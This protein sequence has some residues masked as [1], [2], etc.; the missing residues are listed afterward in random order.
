MT[1][2]PTNRESPFAAEE[3]FFSTT[4]PKGII[5]ASNEVF[6]RV[7]RHPREALDGHAHNRVRHPDMPRAVFSVFWD[8]LNAGRPIAAYVKNLAADGSWYWVMASVVP[9]AGGFLSVRLKPSTAYLTAA[10]AVYVRL[11]EA[12]AEVEGGDVR[13]R[14]AAITASVELLPQLLAQEGFASYEA[15]MNV[16]LPAEVTAREALL[17]TT[18]RQRLGRPPTVA[19]P[20]LVALLERCAA[21]HDFLDHLVANLEQFAAL[22]RTLED[23]SRFVSDLADS[24]RLFSLNAL[25]ASTRL[26]ADGAALGAVAGLMRSRSDS[27]GPIIAGLSHEI[28]GAVDL[29]GDMGFRIAATKLQT[30]MLMDF[31]HEL[32]AGDVDAHVAAELAPLAGAMAD[33]TEG[34]LASLTALNGHL[35]AVMQH[36]GALTGD[37]NQLRALEV[38]GRIEAA[39]AGESGNV[40]SLFATIG[41]QV[42]AARLEMTGFDGVATVIRR[43]DAG[44][45]AL[46][47]E[48]VGAVRERVAALA[49]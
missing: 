10:Q 36:V 16:A 12:E 37:L 6:V 13:R 31:T 34:L 11:L 2:L 46:V 42:G 48:H 49:A 8:A 27:A 24:I 44:A 5:R 18:A 21:T 9:V 19:D 32:M 39:K 15:F 45:Q 22:N 47:L 43:R 17:G 25:V 38:N 3:L 20:D 33:G 35:G 1:I 26:G 23:K 41:E 28:T 4:D 29:L 40:K 7:S 14:K 30:E